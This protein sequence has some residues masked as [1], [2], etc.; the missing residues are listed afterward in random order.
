MAHIK[1]YETM[2][3]GIEFRSR[4][5]AAWYIYLRKLGFNPIYEPETFDL[6]AKTEDENGVGWNVGPYLPDF[7]LPECD[8]YV[9]IK[10]ARW[11]FDNHDKKSIHAAYVLGYT[12]PTIIVIGTPFDYVA[13]QSTERWKGMPKG[14]LCHFGNSSDPGVWILSECTVQ[15]YP[16]EQDHAYYFG[17][18]R[19]EPECRNLKPVFRDAC[20]HYRDIACEAWNDT[21]WRP[22]NRKDSQ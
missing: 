18:Y 12:T 6:P 11:Y 19:M 22:S 1:A 13:F 14:W 5:E 7:Y 16:D 3:D 21:K 9:E 17:D 4:L 2:G 15:C 10:P 20:E 8:S